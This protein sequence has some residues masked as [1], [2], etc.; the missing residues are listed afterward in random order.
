MSK[1]NGLATLDTM[2]EVVE[3]VLDFSEMTYD[4]AMQTALIEAKLS[5][6][7]LLGEKMRQSDQTP[8]EVIDELLVLS[9]PASMEALFTRTRML[10]A[11]MVKAVP[12]AWFVS[13]A[14]SGLPLDDPETYRWLR[15]ERG[16]ELQQMIQRGRS[17]KN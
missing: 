15:S 8:V 16:R 17:A 2:D 3:V 12:R 6:V 11:K 14:P 10:M 4:D 5:R 1:D 9:N 7:S 13:S